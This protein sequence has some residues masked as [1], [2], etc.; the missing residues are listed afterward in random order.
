MIVSIIVATDENGGIGIENRLPWRLSDDLRHF[1]ELTTGHHIIMGRKTYESIGKPLPG[2]TSIV[3]TRNPNFRAQGCLIAHSLAD[4]LALAQERGEDEVFI[5]GGA[6]LYAQTIKDADRLYLT[7][8]HTQIRADAFFP[9]FDESGWEEKSVYNHEADERNEY[10]FTF[11]KLSKSY[12]LI[13][14]RE[15]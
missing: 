4:A 3:I 12:R 13:V 1:K 11:R 14:S 9:Q 8:V 2:R 6:S 5:C 7:R 10:P 15:T